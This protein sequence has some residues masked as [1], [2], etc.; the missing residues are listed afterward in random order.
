MAD[1][2]QAMRQEPPADAFDA[3]LHPNADAGQ[4]WGDRGEQAELAAP[5]LHER[6]DLH[7]RFRNWYDSDLKQVPVLPPGSRLQQG[8]TYLDLNDP[9]R[10]PFSARGDTTA[11]PGQEIVPKDRVS[12]EVWNRLLVDTGADETIETVEE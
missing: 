1:I 6:K 8:A 7:R 10:G 4:N 5:T 9:G 2:K 11:E 12:Y 3:D